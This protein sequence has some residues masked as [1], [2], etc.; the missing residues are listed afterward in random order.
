MRTNRLPRGHRHWGDDKVDKVIP[1]E[2]DELIAR[3]DRL[4]E[5]AAADREL[6]RAKH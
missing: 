4:E 2:M 5:S 6:V 1:P 3:L